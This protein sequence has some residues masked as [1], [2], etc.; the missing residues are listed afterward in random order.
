MKIKNWSWTKTRVNKIHLKVDEIIAYL[1]R[2]SLPTVLVEGTDD[3][4]VYRYIEGRLGELDVDILICNGRE[5]LLNI[6]TRKSE[7]SNAKVAFVAD[8]D[9]WYFT[10]IPIEYQEGIIFSTGYSLEN[11]LYVKEIFESLLEQD[12]KRQ[13]MEL[14]RELSKWFAFEVTRYKKE[15]NA[16]CDV[17]I[18]RITNGNTLCDR[19]LNDIGFI[20]PD[21]K[22]VQTIIRN[23]THAIRG[24]NL[25]QAILRFLSSSKRPSKYSRANLLE[26]GAKN[27][28]VFIENLYQSI[29]L[30][31][32]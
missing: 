23:Y 14:L 10:G 9:M 2:T 27:D 28:N 1:K 20:E 24:K 3:K 25:F 29:E 15:G 13:Y 22:L 32:S 30:C 17:H 8:K 6:F 7:F 4:S 16:L 19:Y 26:L 12:E 21:Q 31:I 5:A 18:N 11:D